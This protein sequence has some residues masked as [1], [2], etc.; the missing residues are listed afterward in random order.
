M[1]TLRDLQRDIARSLLVPGDSAALAHIADGVVD[2]AEQFNVYR[3]NVAINLTGALRLAYPVIDKL[4]G[5]D[6]FDG[7]ARAFIA[8]YPP[9][10]ACLDD[11]GGEFPDYLTSFPAAAALAY[12]PD[13]ARLEW[14]VNTALHA[15]DAPAVRPDALADLAAGG[16]GR[17]R[18]LPHPSVRLLSIRY[19]ADA[20]WRAVLDGDEVALGTIAIKIEPSWLIVQRQGSGIVIVHLDEDEANWTS[21]LFSGAAL[22]EVMPDEESARFTALLADHLVSGRFAGFTSDVASGEG[23]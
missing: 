8:Q 3:N 10:T 23:A 16:H 21:L 5:P 4:V 11:Y 15:P 12:L 22:D 14:A 2:A 17:V 13:V 7:A 6:F 18:F 1:P 9:R 19:P 20:I